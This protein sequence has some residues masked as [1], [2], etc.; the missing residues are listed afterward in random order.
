VS[1]DGKDGLR[2][3]S[4]DN[5]NNV[6]TPWRVAYRGKTIKRFSTKRQAANFYHT[7][8]QTT[9]TAVANYA[10]EYTPTI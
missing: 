1:G 2:G 3:I 5:S 6:K 9:E 7:L 4:Y 8:T 10:D